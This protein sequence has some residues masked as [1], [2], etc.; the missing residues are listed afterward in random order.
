[1]V[2]TPG[3]DVDFVQETDSF[4]FGVWLHNLWPNGCYAHVEVEKDSVS[5]FED[6]SWIDV[7]YSCSDAEVEIFSAES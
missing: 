2:S 6:S 4:R 3:C 7:A 5:M 1:L